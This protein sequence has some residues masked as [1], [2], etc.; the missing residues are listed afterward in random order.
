M[1]PLGFRQSGN[2]YRSRADERKLRLEVRQI[3]LKDLP[4]NFNIDIE[5]VVDNTISQA[6]E[7]APFDLGALGPE[8][9]RQAVGCFPDDFQITYD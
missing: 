7:F 4:N 5:I 3:L 1:C 6:D 9:L 2:L 8:I